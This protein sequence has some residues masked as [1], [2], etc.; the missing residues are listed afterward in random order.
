MSCAPVTSNVRAQIQSV[1]VNSIPESA[2]MKVDIRSSAELEMAALA[3]QVR[4][5]AEAAAADESRRAS[6][7]A[8]QTVASA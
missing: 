5:I 1:M 2:S 6:R 4:E 3:E 7:G 8:W